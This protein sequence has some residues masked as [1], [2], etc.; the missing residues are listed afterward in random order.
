MKSKYL[1]D[2]ESEILKVI[3][4]SKKALT[5]DEILEKTRMRVS[6]KYSEEV[7]FSDNSINIINN[8]IDDYIENNDL[9]AIGNGY[10]YIGN[11]SF[12]K[13]K[14]SVQRNGSGVV[15]E[16]TSYIKDGEIISQKEKYTVKKENLNGAHDGDLVLIDVI[17]GTNKRNSLIKIDR[18]LDSN[19]DVLYGEVCRDRNYGFY[20]KPVNKKYRD[21]FVS[22]DS[23]LINLNKHWQQ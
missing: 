23:N 12:H 7:V 18:I 4:K 16:D 20:V 19:L 14:L 15:T 9:I 2:I 5:K 1:V 21:L 6:N 22:I 17:E 13:G 10:K 3:K 11:T 8:I